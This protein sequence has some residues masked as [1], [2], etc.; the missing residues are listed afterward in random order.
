MLAA[1]LSKE[2][3][4]RWKRIFLKRMWQWNMD[5]KRSGRGI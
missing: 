2:M 1:P 5:K 4:A 3:R